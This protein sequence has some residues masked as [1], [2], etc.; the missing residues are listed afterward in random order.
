[1]TNYTIKPG[2]TLYKIAARH[3]V[4]LADL[5][6][7]N[8]SI[9]DPNKIYAGR[10]LSISGFRGGGATQ[11]AVQLER[12]SATGVAATD[13]AAA[14]ANASKQ[15]GQSMNATGLCMRGVRL[16][17]EAVGLPLRQRVL[18]AH[19]LAN[20]LQS[21]ERYRSVGVMTADEIR[22][23]PPGYIVVSSS[24]P[25]SSSGH[26]AVTQGNGMESSD[27]IDPLKLARGATFRVF[28]PV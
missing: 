17:M 1:M 7:A 16:A 12:T 20:A 22:K 27:S 13:K 2:D 18:H 3:G 11:S 8:S 21:D 15:V 19:E 14:L 9:K 26:A 25:E 5:Q 24:N 28:V 6:R 23:L 4:S 10:S